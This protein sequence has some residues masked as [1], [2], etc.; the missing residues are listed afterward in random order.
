MKIDELN[1][2]LQKTFYVNFS[3]SVKNGVVFIRPSDSENNLFVIRLEIKDDI[4][5]SI[6][7]EPEKYAASFVKAI[8]E[9]QVNKREMF[10]IY[11][12]KLLDNDELAKTNVKINDVDVSQD[13]F[14]KY[15]TAWNKFSIRYTRAPYF[16]RD[17]EKEKKVVDALINIV[18]M[19]L[20]LVDIEFE[21]FEEGSV[22]MSVHKKYE[23]N[24]INRRICLSVKGYRCSVCGK[25]LEEEYGEVAKDVIEVHHAVPVSSMGEGYIVDPIKDLYPVCPNCH[26]ILHKKNPPYTI[27]E[28]RQLIGKGNK[29]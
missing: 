17:D 25:L 15:S 21:G 20:S 28:A 5:L 11:W 19:M 22:T 12:E 27:D 4:R 10:C 3:T 2:I 24:P 7:C 8:S 9:S 6:E 13:D 29:Q 26:T 23:R 18:G 14:K 1:Q 16:D